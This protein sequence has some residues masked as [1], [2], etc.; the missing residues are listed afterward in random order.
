MGYDESLCEKNQKTSV[1]VIRNMVIDMYISVNYFSLSVCRFAISGQFLSPIW[2]ISTKANKQNLIISKSCKGNVIG[3]KC[4]NSYRDDYN[5][6]PSY[7]KY[8]EFISL[9]VVWSQIGHWKTQRYLDGR[10]IVISLRDWW[11]ISYL[12][13][14]ASSISFKNCPIIKPKRVI[15]NHC[16]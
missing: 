12:L 10:N 3:N 11:S 13:L 8:F 6:A 2:A 15:S 14:L 1:E 7:L 16:L 4:M 5:I 9:R